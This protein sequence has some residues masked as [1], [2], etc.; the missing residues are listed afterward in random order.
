VVEEEEVEAARA[1]IERSRADLAATADDLHDRLSPRQAAGR[2]VAKASSRV[3]Q[4]ASTTKRVVIGV[5]LEQVQQVAAR[6][7]ETAGGLSDTTAAGLTGAST[8]LQQTAEG[9]PLA[10]GVVAF[11]LGLLAATVFPPSATER[12]AASSIGGQLAP[13][14]EHLQQAAQDVTGAVRE[15]AQEAAQQVQETASDATQSLAQQSKSAA[16]E[17][18]TQGRAAAQEIRP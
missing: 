4:A 9:N 3:R 17:V 18:T 14:T 16:T 1:Q 15:S 5:P 11:G 2:Q 13:V 8:R 12:Q 10:A 6:V 7:G